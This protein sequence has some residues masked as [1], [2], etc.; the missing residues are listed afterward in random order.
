MA[1]TSVIDDYVAGLG[2]ALKGPYRPKRDL[3]IEARDSLLDTADALE[4]DGLGRAAAELAAVREFGPLDEIAPGYQQELITC[5]GRRLATVLFLTMPATAL[6]WSV[7]WQIF[8]SD[9]LDLATAPW[10]FVPLARAI[11]ITQMLIGV[12]GAVVLVL[13]G[14]GLRRVRRPERLT[15]RLALLIWGSLPVSIVM[16]VTLA[17]GSADADGFAD[18]PPGV[19]AVLISLLL[20]LVQ[21]Y[22]ASHCLWV[23]RR[24]AA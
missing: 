24:S 6:M 3:V 5:A 19:G 13:L 9:P 23:S 2:S 16:C 17:Y 10:W 7:I 4:G 8:P 18:Y 15:R 11:D 22:C 1:S 21:L 14:R 20:W 12:T